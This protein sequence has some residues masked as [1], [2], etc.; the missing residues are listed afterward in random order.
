MDRASEEERTTSLSVNL[1]FGTEEVG[2]GGVS[3]GE[4]EGRSSDAERSRAA[5]STSVCVSCDSAALFEV[6]LD[7]TE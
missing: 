3:G 5:S 6:E 7:A 2:D 4:E 1:R